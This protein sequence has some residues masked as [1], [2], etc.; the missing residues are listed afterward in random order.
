M[1]VVGIN[2]AQVV[3]NVDDHGEN[4]VGCTRIN[5][6]AIVGTKSTLDATTRAVVILPPAILNIL[7]P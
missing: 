1:S 6:A 2:Q 7:M 3:D 4:N 5:M